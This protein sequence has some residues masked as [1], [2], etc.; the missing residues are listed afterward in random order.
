MQNS[1]NSMFK[2]RWY[3][4]DTRISVAV[5]LVTRLPLELQEVLCTGISRLAEKDYQV[6]KLMSQFKSMGAEKVLAIHKSHQKRRHY[7]SNAIIHKTI[8][9]LYILSDESRYFIANQI[10]ELMQYIQDYLTLCK[11]YA[12]PAETE[13][14]ENIT[15][16]YVDVSPEAARKIL[17][18]IEKEFLVAVDKKVIQ[19][20]GEDASRLSVTDVQPNSD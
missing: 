8:N 19:L 17:K 18:H 15:Y 20:S 4:Q 6:T 7:D 2:N 14:I 16:T 3:D 12:Q 11:K 9:F 5:Q 13:D 10:I 1:Q